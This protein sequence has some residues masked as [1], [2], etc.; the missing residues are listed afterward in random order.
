MELYDATVRGVSP[1][2]TNRHQYLDRARELRY[3]LCLGL[4]VVLTIAMRFWHLGSLPPG[5]DGLEA[6]WALKALDLVQHPNHIIQVFAGGIGNGLFIVAES[7]AIR[8]HGTTATAAR[9][10]P[11][12][13]GSLGVLAIYGWVTSWFGKRAGLTAGFLAAVVP[14]FVVISRYDSPAAF[15]PLGVALVLWAATGAIRQKN[16]ILAL[17]SGFVGALLLQTRTAWI[18]VV[19]LVLVAAKQLLQ[20]KFRSEYGRIVAFATGLETLVSIP[21]IIQTVRGLHWHL[22][23]AGVGNSII[24]GINVISDTLLMLVWRGDPSFKFNIG[25]TPMLNLFIALMLVVGLLVAGSRSR[26]ARYRALLGL[27]LAGVVLTAL[28]SPDA[29]S[30]YGSFLVAPLAVAL[31][32]VGIEYMLGTWYSTFP[33]NAAARTLG[34]VPIVVLLAVTGY[35]GYQQYFVAW[36]QSPEV[37]E[38]YNERAAGL[39]DFLVRDVFTGPR[40]V[41]LTGDDANVVSFLTYRKASYS[42][43]RI[44]EI[45]AL[46]QDD[47]ARQFILIAS[48]TETEISKLKAR[49]PKARLSQHYSSF[50][51]SNELFAVYETKP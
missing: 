47:Q 32:A 40:Y 21:L 45:D 24:H 22:S 48:P 33:I 49:Y 4:I 41:L 30:A 37:Y 44:S 15:V 19:V 51:D 50:N 12:I 25:G 9:I 11:A 1:M 31:A 17:E 16:W 28:T 13:G 29:P 7:I 43:L 3:E 6:S 8:I 20:P 10:V 5:L 27:F 2:S 18:Y 38:A 23:L 26:Q 36:A 46:P 14:W 35:Q 42:L 39:S 34:I